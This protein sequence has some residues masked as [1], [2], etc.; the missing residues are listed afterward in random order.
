L[1][2]LALLIAVLF[3]VGCHTRTLAPAAE[4]DPQDVQQ[5]REVLDSTLK[6]E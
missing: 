4:Y 5:I 1:I 3:P 6:E 2:T